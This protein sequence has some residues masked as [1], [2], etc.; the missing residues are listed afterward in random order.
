MIVKSFDILFGRLV[1]F[2]AKSNSFWRATSQRGADRTLG[3]KQQAFGG[4]LL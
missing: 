3:H 4:T 1:E 2:K